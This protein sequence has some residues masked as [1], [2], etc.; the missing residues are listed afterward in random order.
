MNK[1]G[2]VLN[3]VLL[4]V[5]L[6]IVLGSGTGIPLLVVEL[7]IPIVL[8]AL[9]PD[10]DTVIGSHRKT[11]HNLPVLALFISF[12]II[13]GNLQYVWVGVASH[14]MLDL[15]CGRRGLALFYPLPKEYS[16]S[17]G[18]PQSGRLSGL[19]ATLISIGQILLAAGFVA[20]L[21]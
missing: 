7:L 19:T 6:A 18:L 17:V 21:G 5:G 14:Y 13:F 11:L 4:S 16:M 12:P 3:A 15:L 10:I 8:G 2:H 20:L 1:S 9:F